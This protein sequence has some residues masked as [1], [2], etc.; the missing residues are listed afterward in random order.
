MPDP[1]P[2][3]VLHEC[4]AKLAFVADTLSIFS[5][6]KRANFSPDGLNG[7]MYIVSDIERDLAAVEPDL[8]YQPDTTKGA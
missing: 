5:F 1:H 2:G 7:L 8:V 3:D 4:I 6:H